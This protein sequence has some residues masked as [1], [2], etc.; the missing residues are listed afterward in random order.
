MWDFT[1]STFQT[2]TLVFDW[3]GLLGPLLG[4]SKPKLLTKPLLLTLENQRIVLYLKKTLLAIKL[5]RSLSYKICKLIRKLTR[6]KC[7]ENL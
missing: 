4:S 3:A 5:C 1:L 2:F 6:K 7:R